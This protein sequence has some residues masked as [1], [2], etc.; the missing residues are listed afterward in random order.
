MEERTKKM[1]QNKVKKQ[2]N[3]HKTREVHGSINYMLYPQHLNHQHPHRD[4][5]IIPYVTFF[6]CHN[7]YLN[8][9]KQ[10]KYPKR[11]RI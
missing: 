4:E 3:R 6:F 1:E 5:N 8:N 7:F 2:M 11:M 10:N 9:K